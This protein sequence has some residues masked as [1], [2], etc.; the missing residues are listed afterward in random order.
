MVFLAD[1]GNLIM[2][3]ATMRFL[4]ESD[5]TVASQFS[6]AVDQNADKDN[7]PELLIK[8]F[9]DFG[10]TLNEEIEAFREESKKLL[11]G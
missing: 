2:E 7:L 8:E 5:Q 11:E 4:V 9:P 1:V 3:S 6:Q 10:T